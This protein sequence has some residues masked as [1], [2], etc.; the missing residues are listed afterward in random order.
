M[1]NYKS[2][3]LLEEVKENLIKI[4]TLTP[5]GKTS[6]LQKDPRSKA[7]KKIMITGTLTVSF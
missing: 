4:D 7:M 1:S 6:I 3:V 5:V 2:S